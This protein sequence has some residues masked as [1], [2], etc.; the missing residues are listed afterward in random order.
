V[1]NVV[2]VLDFESVAVFVYILVE[3][4]FGRRIGEVERCSEVRYTGGGQCREPTI[5]R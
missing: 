4:E 1:G 2:S 3:L 5:Y